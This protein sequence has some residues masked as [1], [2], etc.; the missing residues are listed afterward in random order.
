MDELQAYYCVKGVSAILSAIGIG[1]SDSMAVGD[2]DTALLWMGEE[3]NTAIKVIEAE[4][5]KIDK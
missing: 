5:N 3:L 1:G 4:R 2:L